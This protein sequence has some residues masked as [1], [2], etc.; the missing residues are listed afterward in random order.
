MLEGLAQRLMLFS[1]SRKLSDGEAACHELADLEAAGWL[2]RAFWSRIWLVFV[3]LK[4][5]EKT[6]V[7]NSWKLRQRIC[8][9]VTMWNFLKFE[10]TTIHP[11]NSMQLLLAASEHQVWYIVSFVC[12]IIKLMCFDPHRALTSCPSW[13]DVCSWRHRQC[14]LV[15]SHHHNHHHRQLIEADDD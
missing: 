7:R 15:L 1:V 10:A 9:N 13:W 6:T 4:A 5:C 14:E 2:V 3:C 8:H 12:F 11:Q